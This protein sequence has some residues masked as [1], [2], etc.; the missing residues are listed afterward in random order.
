MNDSKSIFC[1]LAQKIINLSLNFKELIYQNNIYLKKKKDEWENI[2]NSFR[3]FG[4]RKKK[5]NNQSISYQSLIDKNGKNLEDSIEGGHLLLSMQKFKNYCLFL[6]K[7]KQFSVL[8]VLFSV[9]LH[10]NVFGNLHFSDNAF[11]NTWSPK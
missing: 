5:V 8:L 7:W 4:Q 10:K 2:F 6:N 9:W 3:R 11:H 1:C